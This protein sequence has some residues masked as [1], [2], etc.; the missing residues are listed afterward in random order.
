M[1]LIRSAVAKAGS[2]AVCDDAFN[3]S[4]VKDCQCWSGEVC[5]Q[6]A[7]EVEPLLCLLDDGCG[8]VAGGQVVVQMHIQELGA[9]NLL[10][11]RSID[12]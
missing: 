1:S 6:S 7:E 5:L 4:L 2:N 11:H 9:L 10:Y 3:G 8:V 12:G